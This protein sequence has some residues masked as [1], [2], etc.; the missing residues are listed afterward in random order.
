[1]TLHRIAVKTAV[2]E[3]LNC[4]ALINIVVLTVADG[5]F[6]LY[7]S[8]RLD[9]LLI[10][11]QSPHPLS[12]TSLMISVDVKHHGRG[13]SKLVFYAQSTG[14]MEEEVLRQEHD[15]QSHEPS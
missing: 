3:V 13:V 12:L 14:T 7:G 11:T 8:E 10:R 4:F 2:S 9:E 5:L 1:M 6:G 15:P